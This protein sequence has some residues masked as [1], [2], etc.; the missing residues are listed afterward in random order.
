[1]YHFTG[2]WRQHIPQKHWQHS[3]L[4]HDVTQ[5]GVSII[6][7][8]SSTLKQTITA[9]PHI[10][11]SFVIR[12]LSQPPCV[13]CGHTSITVSDSGQTIWRTSNCATKLPCICGIVSVT[14][15][16]TQSSG[17][18]QQNCFNLSSDNA[19]IPIIWCLRRVIS[20]PEV[21]PTSTSGLHIDSVT[22]SA[23]ICVVCHWHI[24][25]PQAGYFKF[26][27]VG[28]VPYCCDNASN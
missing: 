3:P 18:I 21:F 17:H 19:E 23:V 14:W 13:I 20:R 8:R 28:I 11:S 5:N 24:P 25:S 9:D 16:I 12:Q 6:K 22:L 2:V 26:A 4:T 15:F 1:M 7:C 10:L 27:L